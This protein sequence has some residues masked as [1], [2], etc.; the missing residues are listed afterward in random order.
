MR[1]EAD[2]RARHGFE[3]LLLRAQAE[4]VYYRGGRPANPSWREKVA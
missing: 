1:K 4:K 3:P 2:T